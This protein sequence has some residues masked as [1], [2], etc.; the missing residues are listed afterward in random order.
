MAAEA[1]QSARDRNRVLIVDELRRRRAAT[2]AELA[3]ATGLSRATIAAVVADLGA[4]GLVVEHVNGV[5]ART[6]AARG[7]PAVPLRLDTPA[8]GAIGVDFGHDHVWVAVADLS[9]T[10]LGDRFI[11][12]DVDHRADDALTAA[13]DAIADLL[14]ETGLTHGDVIGGG[15]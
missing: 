2:R 12:L 15:V 1:T 7:R 6:R 13:A 11:A 8:G 3:R 10:M 9:S 4:R 5:S 14:D